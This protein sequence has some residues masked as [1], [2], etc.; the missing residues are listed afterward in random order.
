MGKIT[1]KSIDYTFPHKFL[2]LY[3]LLSSK[4]ITQSVVMLNICRNIWNNYV[5]EVET[6]K[7]LNKISLL[8]LP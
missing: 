6:V 5:Y 4:I 3:L 2:K 8:V 7:G 1:S